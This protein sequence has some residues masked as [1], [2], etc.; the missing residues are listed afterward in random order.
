LEP[1][2]A[3]CVLTHDH[4][5]AMPALVAAFDSKVGYLGAM[6]ART[7]EETEVAICAEIIALRSGV[8]ATS[9]REGSGPIHQVAS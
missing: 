1:L 7:P 9:L 8:T 5:F 6:G 2:D 4:K 3:I